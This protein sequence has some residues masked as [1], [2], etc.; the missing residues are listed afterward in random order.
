MKTLARVIGVLVLMVC[1]PAMGEG[2]DFNNDGVVGPADLQVLADAFF[3]NAQ[4]PDLD[5]D[6]YVGFRDLALFRQAYPATP[7]ALQLAKGRRGPAQRLVELLP[8]SQVVITGDTV[9]VDVRVDFSGD[10]VLGGGMDIVYDDTVL[11][12]EG[13]EFSAEYSGEPA[14]SRPPDAMAGGLLSGLAIGQFFGGIAGPETIGTLRFTAITSGTTDLV[15]SDNL[16]PVGGFISFETGLPVSVDYVSAS[17]E[18]IVGLSLSQ[19]SLDFGEVIGAVAEQELTVSNQSDVPVTIGTVG[20]ID[21]LEAPFSIVADSCSG[22]SLGAG[23]ACFVTAA[24]ESNVSD[25]FSDSFDIPTE[26][27]AQPS[28]TVPVT[29]SSVQAVAVDIM[30]GECP[31][32]LT[33]TGDVFIMVAI[34]GSADYGTNW[35]DPASVRLNGVPPRRSFS[36]DIATP[37]EPFVGK[38]EPTDCNALNGDGFN[39][40]LLLFERSLILESLP[41]VQV[42]D[43]IVLEL[44]AD[45]RIVYPIISG[46]GVSVVGEDVV[47]ITAA[48]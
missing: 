18:V 46:A 29:A 12:Y 36:V 13:F 30:P 31:N 42:G 14:F 10:P 40:Q 1:Q 33:P 15:A 45:N 48:P 19:P 8:A 11:Q 23:Q 27:P 25:S 2:A 17:V 28:I 16:L 20:L 26:N 4:Q 7:Q 37:Y 34:L 9:A 5:R 38:T 39:D 32:E 24:F 44:T 41:F 3:S 35:I 43:A 6:G 47:V 22:V 21:P